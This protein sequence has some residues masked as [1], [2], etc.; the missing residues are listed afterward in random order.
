MQLLQIF[1]Q[2]HNKINLAK[3]LFIKLIERIPLRIKE[4]NIAQS[5]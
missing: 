3:K 2:I 5:K 4:K 1:I